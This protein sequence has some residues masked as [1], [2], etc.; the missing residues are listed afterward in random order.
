MVVRHSPAAETKAESRFIRYLTDESGRRIPTIH[1]IKHVVAEH[2]RVTTTNIDS[3]SR[4]GQILL[5]APDRILPKPRDDTEVIA[6]HRAAVRRARPYLC[7]ERYQE[8][9]AMPQD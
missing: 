9:R 8:D 5:A 3:Q 6:R 1:E 2:F 7:F 4:A